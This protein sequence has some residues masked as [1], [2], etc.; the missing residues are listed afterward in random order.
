MDAASTALFFFLVMLLFC[1]NM[2]VWNLGFYINRLKDYFWWIN[3]ITFR[4]LE[5][6]LLCLF[7]YSRRIWCPVSPKEITW[8]GH[9]VVFLPGAQPQPL[10]SRWLWGEIPFWDTRQHW[11]WHQW[12][13]WRS[14]TAPRLHG[15][16]SENLPL[17]WDKQRTLQLGQ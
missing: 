12:L 13:R 10:I 1:R 17:F 2:A 9:G 8:V 16:G 3:K 6:S 5:P 14:W 11:R 15:S 7:L 4:T